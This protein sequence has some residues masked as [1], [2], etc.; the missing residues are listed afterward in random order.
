MRREK[1]LDRARNSFVAIFMG[2][3]PAMIMIVC[4]FSVDPNELAEFSVDL[5]AVEGLSNG[6]VL[7]HTTVSP[8]FSLTV[9]AQ[10]PSTLQRWCLNGGEVVVSYAGVA[11]AWG[12]VPLFC[13]PRSGAAE[14]SV[15]PW[16]REVGLPEDLRRRLVSE[17][18]VGT[19][20]V[21]VEMKIFHLVHWMHS[22]RY[23][24]DVGTSLHSFKF[25]LGDRTASGGPFTLPT[26]YSSP[27]L[28]TVPYCY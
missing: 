26:S 5:G 12:R 18:R 7:G 21:L 23:S 17:R 15:V 14:L 25:M 3:I 19:A 28:H 27:Y 8:A 13:V 24:Y 4:F 9:R 11:L 20:E 6:T 1:V 2:G 22:S 16:G 10:N